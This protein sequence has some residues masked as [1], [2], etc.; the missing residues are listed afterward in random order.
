MHDLRK[1]V[2]VQSG[3]TQSRKAR[4]REDPRPRSSDPSESKK[5]PGSSTRASPLSS[6][7]GSR[8]NSRPGSRY[9]SEDEGDSD[10]FLGTVTSESGFD[11]DDDDG[12]LEDREW[13]SRLRNRISQLQES[14]RRNIS[15][16]ETTLV[17]YLHLIRHY[18][19]QDQIEGSLDSAIFPALISSIEKGASEKE[20]LAALNAL[21]VTLLTCPSESVFDRVSRKLKVVC[22]ESE[23]EMVK[24]AAMHALAISLVFEGG[25]QPDMEDILEF[26]LEIVE[27]DGQTVNAEDSGAVVTGALQAWGCIA[28][29]LE[30]L[31]EVTEDGRAMDAFI[32]QLDSTDAQVQVSAGYNIAQLFEAARD[33][34]T[35]S[36]KDTGLQHSQHLAVTRMHDIVKSWTRSTSKKDRRLLRDEFPAI[37]ISIEQG[38]GPGYAET[39]DSLTALGLEGVGDVEDYL[40]DSSKVVLQRKDRSVARQDGKAMENWKGHARL[41]VLKTVLAGGL[42]WHWRENPSVESALRPPP[43]KKNTALSQPLPETLLP[44]Q[45][46]PKD[47]DLEEEAEGD[48]DEE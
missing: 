10:E 33:S 7:A 31:A 11:S 35:S 40:N 19:T 25:G 24:V 42:D 29:Y 5:S 37:I 36:R 17:S 27:S 34:V 15:E 26:M 13:M 39:G 12:D 23:S 21:S 1:K 4:A 16:R 18:F 48:K 30:N 43:K 45:P 22:E 6:R 32:E 28:S 20:V 44:P 8:N 14:R 47:S 2:L 3:K 9:A 46:R 41:E 38:V